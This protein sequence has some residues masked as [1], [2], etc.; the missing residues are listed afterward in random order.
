MKTQDEQT[1]LSDMDLLKSIV[2]GAFST[3]LLSK[4]RRRD[5][6]DCRMV[7]SKIIRERGHTFKSIGN[8]LYKDHSTIMHYTIQ[9]SNLI[10]TDRKIMD[11]YIN[12]RNKFLENR[13][14]LVLHTDRDL[15]REVLSLRNQL[16]D[17]VFQYEEIKKIEKKYER[18]SD[19]IN[20]IENR[21]PVGK[22]NQIKK[23][24]NE[25]FNE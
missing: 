23:R 24:I 1:I 21:T 12:C 7:F 9:A 15:V 16:D 22:E 20:L 18:L 14:P 25:M 3:S 11:I 19:I 2:E 5:V 4:N 8:Y 13:E 17:L 10:K 6:V